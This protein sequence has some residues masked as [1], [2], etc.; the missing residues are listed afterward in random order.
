MREHHREDYHGEHA[1]YAQLCLV[2]DRVLKSHGLG[3]AESAEVPPA[4]LERLGL[5]EVQTVMVMGR[6]LAACEGLNIMA[7]QLAA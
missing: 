4:V 6:V 2:A 5:S 1:V 7:R 3:E